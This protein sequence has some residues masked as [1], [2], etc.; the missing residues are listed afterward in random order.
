[1]ELS[2]IGLALSSIWVELSSRFSASLLTNPFTAV[3]S[4]VVC[5]GSL[6]GSGSSSDGDG[7]V[8]GASVEG[9]SDGASGVVL[10]DSV[11]GASVGA[12]VV[13][14]DA[15]RR[16]NRSGAEVAMFSACTNRSGKLG[17]SYCPLNGLGVVLGFFA[18]LPP[19]SCADEDIR[20]CFMGFPAMSC[21][22]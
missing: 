6:D 22:S 10:V 5:S 16:A 20:R 7:S 11:V 4:T 21:F 19:E 15:S 18:P 13:V 9:S 2:T 14:V 12:S 8:V 1:M 3:G 17:I